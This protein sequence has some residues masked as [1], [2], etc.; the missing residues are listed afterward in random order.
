MVCCLALWRSLSFPT[1]GIF[2][3]RFNPEAGGP[4]LVPLA[5]FVP[6]ISFRGPVNLGAALVCYQSLIL[7]EH[8]RNHLPLMIASGYFDSSPRIESLSFS[9]NTKTQSQK[10]H[11][12]DSVTTARKYYPDV[13]K[14]LDEPDHAPI[15]GMVV[16]SNG[17][18]KPFA[19]WLSRMSRRLNRSRRLL[20]TLRV[21][22]PFASQ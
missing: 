15:I 19:R 4:M 9:S 6:P 14:T 11:G 1:T 20:P 2:C 13:N 8:R 16:P 12:L 7:A 10:T 5:P 18:G 22:M 3:E 17:M 21:R